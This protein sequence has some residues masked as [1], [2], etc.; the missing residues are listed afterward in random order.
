MLF[1]LLLLCCCCARRWRR[2]RAQARA[3]AH[4]LLL[5]L[6]FRDG[7]LGGGIATHD[8]HESNGLTKVLMACCGLN[9]LR[10]AQVDDDTPGSSE[11]RNGWIRFDSRRCRCG[12]SCCRSLRSCGDARS[13][14]WLRCR[15]LSRRVSSRIGHQGRCVSG[16]SISRAGMVM[17]RLG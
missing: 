6:G 14:S 15:I 5:S 13:A 10:F 4:H 1:L 9:R 12:A 16:V 17:G 11:L 3:R 2:Q 7:R 8:R